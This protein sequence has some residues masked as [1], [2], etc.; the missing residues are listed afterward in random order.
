MPAEIE[1]RFLLR[2]TD[3]D[4]FWDH[5]H[6]INY[7]KQ[8]YLEWGDTSEKRIR[9]INGSQ[10]ML[11]TKV[12]LGIKREENEAEIPPDEGRALVAQAIVDQMPFV[13]KNR[14]ITHDGWELDMYFDPPLPKNIFL[15]EK[16]LK[17]E[18]E[19]V[20]LK[21]PG[22]TFLREVTGLK[23]FTNRN[24]AIARAWPKI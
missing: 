14:F 2:M 24:I 19:L 15:A 4:V 23:E 17:S 22:F 5:P 16:E 9:I 6:I 18:T 1:R 10:Y 8:F 20:T 21:I 3:W 7:I 12:G 13:A 11:A